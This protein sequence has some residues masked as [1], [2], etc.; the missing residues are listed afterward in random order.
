M[1]RQE[2]AN[3]F[4]SGTFSIMLVK[5]TLEQIHPWDCLCMGLVEFSGRLGRLHSMGLC[6]NIHLEM[7]VKL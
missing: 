3:M 4:V 2:G 1:I 6:Q 7:K 5:T